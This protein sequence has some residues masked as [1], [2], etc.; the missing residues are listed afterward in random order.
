MV[1]G[2]EERLWGVDSGFLVCPNPEYA[3][4]SCLSFERVCSGCAQR[5]VVSYHVCLSFACI[6]ARRNLAFLW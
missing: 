4:T 6:F 5:L 3:G 2:L 1:G